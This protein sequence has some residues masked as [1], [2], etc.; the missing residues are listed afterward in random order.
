VVR[1][2]IKAPIATAV[3]LA[4]AAIVRFAFHQAYAKTVLIAFGVALIAYALLP[5]KKGRVEAA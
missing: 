3:F 5:R 2:L 4:A 1:G